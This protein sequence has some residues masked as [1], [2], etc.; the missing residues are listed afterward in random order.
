MSS[1]GQGDFGWEM[2][3]EINDLITGLN[4][5]LFGIPQVVDDRQN[6][7]EV[8]AMIKVLIQ[9]AVKVKTMTEELWGDYVE[10][11]E[12]YTALPSE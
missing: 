10:L 4:D 7:E 8:T 9:K 11:E 3:E 12:K 5:A 1:G 6:R 2:G